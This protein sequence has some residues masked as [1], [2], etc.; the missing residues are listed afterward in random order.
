MKNGWQQ[1]ELFYSYTWAILGYS[2]NVNEMHL[3][4]KNRKNSNPVGGIT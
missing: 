2:N 1:G 3:L 4:D